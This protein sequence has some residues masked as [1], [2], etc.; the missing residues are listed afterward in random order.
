MKQQ[1]VHSLFQR[2]LLTLIILVILISAIF[3]VSIFNSHA[4]QDLKN[5]SFNLFDQRVVYRSNELQKNLAE[6]KLNSDDLKT[7]LTSCDKLYK[8]RTSLQEPY[9][10][11]EILLKL[12]DITKTKNINGIHLIL[13]K[14]VFHSE[15]YPAFYLYDTTPEEFFADKTDITARLGNARLLKE[16][17]FILDQ[18]WKPTLSM[19]E[20]D[21]LYDFYFQPYHA[22]IANPQLT[23]SECGYWSTSNK[24]SDSTTSILSYNVPLFNEAHQFYGVVGIDLS[25]DYLKNY[26]PYEELNDHS[27]KAFLLANKQG[28]DKYHIL[29]S[30]G[31]AYSAYLKNDMDLTLQKDTYGQKI[32]LPA[33]S[34]DTL[35]SSHPIYLYAAAS[36][37]RNKLW[38]LIGVGSE[39]EIFYSHMQI[40]RV[41]MF[42]CITALIIG[43]LVALYGGMLFT[44]PI[45]ALATRLRKTPVTSDKIKLPKTHINEIDELSS[46]I[47][48]LSYHLHGAESRLSY[49]LHTID[50]PIGA[51]EIY[52][53]K[54]VF[55]TE[56]VGYLLNFHEQTK[57]EYTYEDFMAEIQAFN[58]K[59]ISTKTEESNEHMTSDIHL[60]Q[61]CLAPDKISW[62]R[63]LISHVEEN[64]VV[65]VSDV[66]AEIM[67][68]EH[69]MYER[70]HD[71]L[72]QLLNR[73]AFRN[74]CEQLLQN[75]DLKTCAMVLWDLDNLKLVN[76]TYGHDAGDRL[77]C[78]LADILQSESSPNCITA[79]MAGD[80]F[81]LFYHH[82]TNEEEIY[83]HVQHIHE[84]VN[85]TDLNFGK[86]DSI[87]IKVSA[88]ISWL[89]KDAEDYETLVRHADFAMY[90]VKN[91]QKGGIRAFN[92]EHYQH[93]NLLFDGRQELMNILEE[94]R[95]QYAF[96]PIVNA[97][98]AELLGFE[99]LMR[100]LS[101]ILKT[102]LDVMRVA[103]TQKQLHRVEYMTWAQALSRFSQQTSK[104]TTWKLFI[105]S[106]PS[107]PMLDELKAIL[108]KRYRDYLSNI[109]IEL[110]ESEEVEQAYMQTKQDFCMRWN[111]QTALDDFGSGYSSDHRLFNSQANYVKIDMEFI[112]D[113]AHDA[114]RQMLVQNVVNFAHSKQILV[115]AEGVENYEDLR[116]LI[117]HDIDYLQGYCLG[118]PSFVVH[119]ID[120]SIRQQIIE[121]NQ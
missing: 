97:R 99:A 84:I 101:D 36:P 13:D 24:L 50:I 117:Q 68:K 2:L 4:L 40:R 71:V 88:G 54:K 27:K 75:S 7:L 72:T 113:I 77:I 82:F 56:K 30:N 95:V 33:L 44:K 11:K 81:L 105:N 108:E 73:R 41:L 120:A 62:L 106:I 85:T 103:R 63:F 102:P 118:K 8:N 116:Y 16:N 17:D 121:L 61:V 18:N 86:N 89:P 46:A 69:L 20:K 48:D 1:H 35:A 110:L 53:Q 67:E 83:A 23:M 45:R 32:I 119:D 111:A 34:E 66:T 80:E 74:R 58:K 42:A 93:N 90:E 51:I 43:G 98:T 115:I 70:D 79:R 76:D 87:R 59:I 29:M 96:Q 112:K 94:Q 28:T 15:E 78:T 64:R 91:I 10:N 49:V 12:H 19:D 65:V 5:S 114:G 92:E 107:I 22:A 109:V 6:R 9:L 21:P 25:F 3:F 55:C 39:N 31:P 104:D 100:P 26:L 38:Y 52:N 14:N 57:M 37:F 60:V 47:E